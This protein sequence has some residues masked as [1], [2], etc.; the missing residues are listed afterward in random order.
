M[1]PPDPQTIH[2]TRLAVG[3]TQS[4]AAATIYVSLRTWQQWECGDRPM[5]PAFWECF[6]TKVAPLTP[7]SEA[8]AYLAMYMDPM[9]IAG[10]GGSW[11]VDRPG[12]LV[13]DYGSTPNLA[14]E[15]AIVHT[16]GPDI[17]AAAAQKRERDAAAARDLDLR[18]SALDEEISSGN[19]IPANPDSFPSLPSYRG[20]WWP[21]YFMPNPKGERITFFVAARGE[22]GQSV[23]KQA[24]PD[25][26][27]DAAWGKKKSDVSKN[28]NF[29]VIVSRLKEW[30]KTGEGECEFPITGYSI[31]EPRDTLAADIEHIAKQG[32]SLNAAFYRPDPIL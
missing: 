25:D 18:L 6:L 31:G 5:K 8:L 17:C 28:L 22:D 9:I 14:I 20:R 2:D 4:E 30:L 24:I 19:T 23:V 21:V 15:N 10:G 32:L 12:A 3:L 11:R 29:P 27:L 26:L 13:P 1:N 7:K 16:F